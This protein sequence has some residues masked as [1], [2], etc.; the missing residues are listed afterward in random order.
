MYQSQYQYPNQT[1]TN[2]I[3]IFL[4]LLENFYYL[5][6]VTLIWLLRYWYV[7][8]KYIY[9]FFGM[10]LIFDTS[11]PMVHPI[12]LPLQNYKWW[13]RTWS[14]AVAIKWISCHFALSPIG[15]ETQALLIEAFGEIE[16]ATHWPWFKEK[17]KI[18]RL[19]AWPISNFT[20]TTV[21]I[22]SCVFCKICF[23]FHIHLFV[24]SL[25]NI[26]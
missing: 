10:F 23:L 17:D 22:S 12:C 18:F 4:F 14:E 13:T 9:F 1:P 15:I 20:K 19:V 5:Y 25:N 21:F 8:T 16:N 11:V 26:S 7:S 3:C 24:S 2:N 6:Y